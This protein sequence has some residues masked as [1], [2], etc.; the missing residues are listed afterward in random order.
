MAAVLLTQAGFA[1]QS[2]ETVT[3]L[4]KKAQKGYLYNVS[5]DGNL[6]VTYKMPGDKNKDDISFEEYNY[7]ANLNFKGSSPA[8]ENKEEKPNRTVTYLGATVGGGNS[9]NVLGMGLTL[10]KSVYE[11]K[12]DYEDQTY[13]WG[14]RISSEEVKPK[15][16]SG[17]YKGFADYTNYETG[18]V[19]VVAA[20][21]SDKKGE[22]N[23]F[24]LLNINLNLE[25]KETPFPLTGN[26][27]LVYTGSLESG[28]IY[29]VMAPKKGASDVSKYVYLEFTSAGS[30][31]HKTEFT[32]PASNVLIMDGTEKK[33]ALYFTAISTKSKEAYGEVF[34]DYAPINNPSYSGAA[35]AL[36][37]KYEKNAYGAEASSLHLIKVVNGKIEFASSNSI[38]KIKS[39]VKSPASQ[40]KSTP[41]TGKL[42]AVQQFYITP[43]DEILVA[44]QLLDKKVTQTE[45]LYLKQDI[46]C[47]HFNSKGEIKAQYA[48]EKINNDTK[49]EIFSNR[50]V[51]YLSKDG[52]SVYWLLMEVKGTKGYETFWDAYNGNPTFHANYF[53]RIV[54]INPDAALISDV[55]V[56]G[57][58]EY[59]VYKYHSS[60]F[61]EQENA[62]VFFGHDEDWKKLW[63]GRYIFE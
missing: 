8:K 50:Q 60:I 17:K 41:Y 11:Q 16:G 13:V 7:D 14:K 47:L 1:Q 59:M 5:S 54:K 34:S 31:V 56:L 39:V 24:V 4:S 43:S 45:L 40:K 23:Q 12:W 48:I 19:V 15:N 6:K 55:T 33:G 26:Y 61:N 30:L 2:K 18:S 35:N 52:K 51:F 37:F 10:K 49:S 20:F 9:F 58:G 57:K 53:P 38:E 29:T 32:A 63:I 21:D 44:G 42:M 36:Q 62:I 22:D 3:E 27:S 25:V 46:V 28:N